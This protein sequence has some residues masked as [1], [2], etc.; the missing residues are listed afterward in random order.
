MTYPN[1][2]KCFPTYFLLHYQTSENNSLFWNSLSKKKLLS[3]KQIGPN[4]YT[5]CSQEES[6]I[7]LM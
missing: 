6:Y 5:L 2:E 7:F 4:I 1:I 3:S